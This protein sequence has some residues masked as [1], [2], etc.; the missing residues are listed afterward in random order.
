[1]Y[2][3]EMDSGVFGFWTVCGIN[4]LKLYCLVKFQKLLREHFST[5]ELLGFAVNI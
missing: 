3:V 1:M 2:L 5:I 4:F